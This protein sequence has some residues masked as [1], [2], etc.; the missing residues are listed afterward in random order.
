MATATRS[1]LE[2]VRTQFEATGVAIGK[3][4]GEVA[5]WSNEVGKL[6]YNLKGAGES[7]R[8]VNGLAAETG[9]TVEEYK[10]LAVELG[11]IG[12][13]A[14]SSEHAIGSLRAQAEALGTKGG[15]AA[16]ADQVQGLEGV[17]SHMAQMSESQFLRVTAAAAVL[18]KGLNPQGAQR[19]QQQALSFVSGNIFQLERYLGHEVTDKN[20]QVTGDSAVKNLLE[21]RDK[22][23]KQ[24]GGDKAKVRKVLANTLGSYETAQAVMNLDANE[25]DRAQ[26][27][28]P[29]GSDAAARLNDTDAG[30]RQ[31]ADA[32]LSASARELT[33]ASTKL[34][35]AA[36]ALQKFASHSPVTA[37]A[38]TA[39]GTSIGASVLG[40][41]SKNVFGKI[42]G[43]LGLGGAVGRATGDAVSAMGSEARVFVTNWPATMG[44]P[45]LTIDEAKGG[46]PE[47]GGKA[48]SLLK[49]VGAAV[50]AFGVGYSIGTALDEASGGFLSDQ[51][52]G[53][54]QDPHATFERIKKEISDNTALY[55]GRVGK[56]RQSNEKAAGVR[57]NAG[58][59]D[60]LGIDTGL[61]GTTGGEGGTVMKAEAI[62]ADELRKALKDGIN[63]TVRTAVPGVEASVEDDGASG[64]AGSQGS[65]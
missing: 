10:G 32:G 59:F 18:G 52:S 2:G 34:G 5:A 29:K 27:L 63:I 6:T 4:P 38:L 62:Q 20:G 8:G 23:L 12:G 14:G 25:L 1:D 24:Y 57:A 53:T 61:K 28:A 44:G 56:I 26:K 13:V 50:A 15:I 48:P 51:A 42:P 17:I 45:G 19:V 21:Y 46:A 11:T 40:S 3:R 16:F 58:I 22:T 7:I 43:L 49:K 55:G 31:V 60:M 36:D 30:K 54:G 33:G 35:Q 9:R 65:E 64:A 37:T 39:V 41:L 47:L